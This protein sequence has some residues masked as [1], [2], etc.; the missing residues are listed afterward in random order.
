[1]KNEPGTRLCIETSKGKISLKFEKWGSVFAREGCYG[2]V[3]FQLD[4]EKVHESFGL[5]SHVFQ[6]LIQET[7]VLDFNSWT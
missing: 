4:I 2:E 3:R 1:M 5:R 7:C 6:T